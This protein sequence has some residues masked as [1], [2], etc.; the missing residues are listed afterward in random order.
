[1]VR[2]MAKNLTCRWQR[3]KLQPSN[4]L[5]NHL[6]NELEWWS[7]PCPL[8]WLYDH[9]PDYDAECDVCCT[10][11]DIDHLICHCPRF[12]S[13]RQKLSDALRQLDDRPLSVQ[14]LLEHRHRLS[15]AQKAVKAVLCF[16]RTTGLCD[17]L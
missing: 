3:P 16:L 15:S 6:P 2:K 4:N 7:Y 8:Y 12:A 14:M 17:H 10:K 1:M 9:Q 13:E 5:S 11:E